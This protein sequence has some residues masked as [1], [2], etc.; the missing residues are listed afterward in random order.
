MLPCHFC[1]ALLPL[2]SVQELSPPQSQEIAS[3]LLL[4]CSVSNR[5][6]SYYPIPQ[7]FTSLLNVWIHSALR[8]NRSKHRRG[9]KAQKRELNKHAS[10]AAVRAATSRSTRH[11]RYFCDLGSE[12]GKSLGQEPSSCPMQ[13]AT[14]A[15]WFL[16]CCTEQRCFWVVLPI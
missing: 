15:A 16:S 13:H 9:Y 5:P 3:P 10:T 6:I 1:S 11:A 8:G 14:S 4:L 2:P 7:L 12:S